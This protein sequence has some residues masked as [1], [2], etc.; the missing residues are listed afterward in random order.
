VPKYVTITNHLSVD[1]LAS[2]YRKAVDPI[3]RSHF[4][5]VW[6]LAQGKRVREVVEI[7]GYCANWIRILARRYNQDGPQ[8][9]A[10]QRHQN[11]GATPLLSQELQGNLRQV[12]EQASPDGGL[13]TG[14]KVALWIGEQTG[15]KIHVQRGW[16]Y[17]KRVNFSLHIPRPRHYK[18]DKNRQEAFKQDLPEQVKQIQQAHPQ[19]SVE[20]WSMDEHRV[21]LKP[22]VRR[23]W[24]L[25]GHRPII[26]VQHRY[27]WLY[28]F[29]FLH[30]SS[31][32][33][34]WL[35][36]PTV[37]VDVFTIALQHFA[38]S[39]RWTRCRRRKHNAVLLF[40]TIQPV[41]ITP[42]SSIGG[43]PRSPK[44]DWT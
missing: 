36:L 5:I 1:E 11:A 24:A 34:H 43:L 15:R 17:L 21:G 12:L 14:R 3:E 28:L 27:E 23:V 22:V 8:V 18:A 35:P 39:R 31:G 29:G 10:D 26:R 38:T 40:K 42:R 9:L 33:T 4:Q 32:N 19:D 41:F 37:N 2:R 30:P 25:K 13:W 6:L 44:G 7:T 20:L 16:E